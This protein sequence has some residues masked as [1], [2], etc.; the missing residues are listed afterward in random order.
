MVHTIYLSY[1]T[2]YQNIDGVPMILQRIECTYKIWSHLYE[3][4]IHINK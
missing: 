2:L 4:L 1:N 3:D